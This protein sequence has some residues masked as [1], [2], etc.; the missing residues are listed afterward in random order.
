M[1]RAQRGIYD[2]CH[3]APPHPS[4]SSLLRFLKIKGILEEWK[5]LAL[6]SR[7]IGSPPEI[8]LLTITP[9]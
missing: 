5:M 8:T 1:D 3:V 4:Q 6:S 2:T 7:C 9:V